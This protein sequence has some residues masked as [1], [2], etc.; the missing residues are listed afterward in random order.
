MK[1]LFG[2]FFGG[3]SPEVPRE[4]PPPQEARREDPGASLR[5]N[6]FRTE[7]TAFIGEEVSDERFELA[8]RKI[9]GDSGVVPPLTGEEIR[10]KAREIAQEF[11]WTPEAVPADDGDTYE[12]MSDSY[13]EMG[14]RRRAFE[15]AFIEHLGRPVTQGDI[16]EAREMFEGDSQIQ[17][18]WPQ[19]VGE[20]VAAYARRVAELLR[21]PLLR[22][23]E[24]DT[25]ERRAAK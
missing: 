8:K 11:G 2:R 7:L 5:E 12:L 24:D 16:E 1:E 20:E 14:T 22:A 17:E 13:E 6:R 9:S 19:L 18:R 3:R 4:V 23:D 21:E 10:S 25:E 15:E